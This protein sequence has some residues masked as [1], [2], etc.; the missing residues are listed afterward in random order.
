[1]FICAAGDIHGAMDRLYDDVLA[2]EKALGM[3][4]DHVLHVGDF[5]IWPDPN[6]VD[7]ATRKHDG[8][9]DFPVWFAENRA[10][11]RPTIFIKG[12]HEHFTWLDE[13]LKAGRR[14]ILPGLTYLP[15]GD[16]IDIGEDRDR[17]RIGGIGGCHG[18]SNYERRS[19]D[20]QGPAKRHFAQRG[21]ARRPS[22]VPGQVCPATGFLF[23]A[24][25]C[26]PLRAS[27]DAHSRDFGC[28]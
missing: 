15:S 27:G 6:R 1:M 5:G 7:K 16:I 11:P 12:N 22:S 14:T 10:A 13:Q 4:F 26:P 9:G 8:A 24:S 21:L 28:R 17:I 18:S 23:A 20:L 25:E 19:R 2:F 3:R